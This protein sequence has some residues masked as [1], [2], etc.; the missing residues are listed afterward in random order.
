MELVTLLLLTLLF[1]S[2]RSTQKGFVPYWVSLHS[3]PDKTEIQETVVL[4][5]SEYLHLM[6]GEAVQ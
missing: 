6:C 5:T 4:E 3:T 1:P 2:L